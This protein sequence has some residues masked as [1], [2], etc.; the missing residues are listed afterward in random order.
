MKYIS[1]QKRFIVGVIVVGIIVAGV[2]TLGF[3]RGETPT[4][5]T[6]EPIESGRVQTIPDQPYVE[7]GGTIIPVAVANTTALRQKGLSGMLSLS[8][9]EGMYF[10]FNTPDRYQFWMPDMHFPID[11]I[12]IADGKIVGIE[13]SVSNVFDSKHP[14][15]YTPPV[16]INRVLEVNAGFSRVHDIDVGDTITF[17]NAIK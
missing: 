16:S 8:K 5:S 12:W 3:F 17:H 1:T 11:I 15:L 4:V 9:D 13:H 10:I 6:Q 2:T 7:I 14:V